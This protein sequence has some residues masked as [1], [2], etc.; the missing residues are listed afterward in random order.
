MSLCRFRMKSLVSMTLRSL[1][2]CDKRHRPNLRSSSDWTSWR[3]VT[4]DE[5]GH[6]LPY[7]RSH[8]SVDRRETLEKVR[9]CI[10]LTSRPLRTTILF[11]S[12]ETRPCVNVELMA[13]ILA[14][15]NEFKS[16]ARSWNL[17]LRRCVHFSLKQA[18]VS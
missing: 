10:R 11:I 1:S 9:A 5:R 7:S 6:S 15:D 18:A 3:K 2:S 8:L 17:F 16:V 14:Q 13:S 12:E 4:L